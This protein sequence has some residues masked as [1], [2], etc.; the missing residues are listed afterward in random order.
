MGIPETQPKGSNW[1]TYLT[2]IWP[3]ERDWI[4][5]PPKN[6]LTNGGPNGIAY[7]MDR[8]ANWR[9]GGPFDIGDQ[10]TL[11]LENPAIGT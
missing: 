5:W 4:A 3:I 1:E 10:V 2:Q 11:K 8:L 9:T 7:L 6:S